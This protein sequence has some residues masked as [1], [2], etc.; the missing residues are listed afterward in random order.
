MTALWGL[1]LAFSIAARAQTAMEVEA[2][3]VWAGNNE[4][5]IPGDSGTRFSL[6][7][8]LQMDT[9]GA[10]R[11]RISRR[12]AKRHW[13]GLLAAPLEL[14]GRGRLPK[15]VFFNEV[16]FPAGTAAEATYRFDSY[17]VLYR[18]Q[19]VATDKWS[20]ELGGAINVRD[21]AI[22][23]SGP[24][25]SSE[26]KNTG[27]VPLLSLGFSWTL[28]PQFRLRVEGEALAAPQGRALDF[29]AA[30]QHEPSPQFSYLAGYRILEGGADN[31][32]VYTFALF[33]YAVIGACYRF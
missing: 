21:A 17:R 19:L 29:L 8:D 1:A 20:W 24:D 32:E 16:H 30:I 5:A 31:D 6:T 9:T 7:D 12:W 14:E 18:Y 4:V 28:F 27:V 13:L 22:R 3:A 23:L 26:K 33:H 15:D 11:L 25:I 2:A 10:A